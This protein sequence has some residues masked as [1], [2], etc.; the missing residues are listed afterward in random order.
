MNMEKL[1]KYLKLIKKRN[2]LPMHNVFISFHHVDEYYKKELV[3]FGIKNKVFV[4][5]SVS[6][7]DIK[8]YD[9]SQK[10]REKIRDEYLRNST[11]TIVL[12][13]EETWSRKHVD[14]EL[15]SSMYDGKIN[16]KLGII[17]VLLPTTHSRLKIP[18]HEG[19]LDNVFNGLKSLIL[20]STKIGWIKR[21]P[22]LSDRIIDNL[23]KKDAYIS[24]I[25]WN[26]LMTD[27]TGYKLKYM[28]D[29]A[30]IDR[31]K[32]TYNLSQPMMKRNVAI[33]G[34]LS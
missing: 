10:I 16:K 2:A 3:D 20:P 33:Q 19:E 14:W 26:S 32:C 5:Y 18:A 29:C 24:V 13:G 6:N 34:K 30:F 28:I 21:Y 7:G 25:P 31:K 1:S 27:S 17:V 8:K 11:V 12:I 15:Y 4:D 23:L 22:F 9:P